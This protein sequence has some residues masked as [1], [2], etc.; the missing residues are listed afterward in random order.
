MK[1][2]E[3]FKSNHGNLT[4]EKKF[5]CEECTLMANEIAAVKRLKSDERLST[6][7]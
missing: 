1:H 3:V 2:T 4:D 5:E 7:V 6:R